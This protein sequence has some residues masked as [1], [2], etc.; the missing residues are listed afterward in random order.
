[1]KNPKILLADRDVSTG[2]RLRSKLEA[3]GFDV[4]VATVVD[5]AINALE[6]HGIDLLV[7]EPQWAD[8][9]DPNDVCESTVA[10]KAHRLEIPFVIYTRLRSV[11]A[12][13]F[14][15]NARGEAR[16]AWDYILKEWDD[17]TL[18][19]SL[20]ELRGLTIVHLS[21]LHL[22]LTEDG[23]VPWDE[24]Q[25][26]T[27]FL[28]DLNQQPRLPL[29]PIQ[30]IVVSGDVSFQCRPE[31]FMR[32]RVFLERL[33][34]QVGI[35]LER[36][37]LTPGNHDVNRDRARTTV[38]SLKAMRAGDTTWLAKFEEFLKFTESFY[39][40][41]AFH[42]D[43]LYRIVT[44]DE[45]VAVVSFNSCLVEGDESALCSKCANRK[46]R[47]KRH[48]HG[49]INR[50]QVADA[51]GDLAA[52]EF[53]GLRIGA[54]HHH[55]APEGWKARASACQ[56]DHLW[57]YNDPDEQLRLALAGEGFSILLHG[58]RHKAELRRRAAVQ[59]AKPYHFGSGAFWLPAGHSDETANYL[60][61][62]LS[63]LPGRSRVIMRRY[64]PSGD[65]PGFW[66]A[67]VD[68]GHDGDGIVPLE[69]IVLPA[70]GPTTWPVDSGDE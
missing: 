42:P 45:R 34:D 69:G 41:P 30:A 9:D 36:V 54:F 66:G 68:F 62:Q 7:L 31:S 6:S 15:L 48:Y 35:P 24:E 56:G 14:F 58:H 5:S 49:W 10:V 53:E 38:N 32:A 55:I 47:P 64:Y 12:I 13:R 18:L 40:E 28:E 27:R 21:D 52:C 39:G 25:A 20:H 43:R 50:D 37:V 63:P 65:V 16:A 19:N 2:M 46:R 4:E 59:A 1:M 17:R 29:N 11:Q 22:R 67:D 26:T 33:A 8:T 70:I 60:L 23:G 3:D 44:L 51:S 61:V 57:S